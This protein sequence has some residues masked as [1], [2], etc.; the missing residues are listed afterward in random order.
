MVESLSG[1]G[2]LAKATKSGIEPE[3]L[4]LMQREL[5]KTFGRSATGVLAMGLGGLLAMKGLASGRWPEDSKE[6]RLWIQE[7]RSEDSVLID[8]EWRK[9]TGI[10]PLGNLIAVGAQMI[11][12]AE[13]E[14]YEPNPDI[15]F[16]DAVKRWGTDLRKTGLTRA[17]KSFSI[18]AA[19]TVKEQSFLRG[20]S[21]M[22]DAIDPKRGGSGERFI[23]QTGGSF[24]P[25]PIQDWAKFMDPVSRNPKTFSEGIKAVL[26]VYS[27]H[28]SARIDDFG[29]PR[30]LPERQRVTRF[31]DPFLSKPLREGPAITELRKVGFAPPRRSRN[32]KGGETEDEFRARRGREGAEELRALEI[33]FK[34]TRYTG[35][36]R[37][38]KQEI[39][40]VVFDDVR[41]RLTK[42]GAPKSWRPIVSRAVGK[43]LRR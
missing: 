31:F 36:S 42:R 15:S 21:D 27:V 7:G 32:R 9:T 11:L 41:T 39:L 37:E 24:V 10:A 2:E 38:Q 22:L 40:S 34:D 19:K 18:D 29:R 23:A 12:D 14:D 33:V 43:G 3:T 1:L 6:A 26:P 20:L 16:G 30:V 8:G 17:A 13:K 25:I 28:V 4:R 35:G 5:V